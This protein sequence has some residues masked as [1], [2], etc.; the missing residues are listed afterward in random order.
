M[1]NQ[2]AVLKENIRD[3]ISKLA[4]DT[5][6]DRVCWT[7]FYPSQNT[8]YYVATTK[9]KKK[10]KREI[11]LEIKKKRTEKGTYAI[12]YTEKYGLFMSYSEIKYLEKLIGERYEQILKK[13]YA[14]EKPILNTLQDTAKKN[15]VNESQ[16]VAYAAA[17]LEMQVRNDGLVHFLSNEC[18]GAAP[19]ICVALETL[20]AA[21]HLALLQ[22][23]LTKNKVDLTD[24]SV[25][26][27]SELDAFSKLNEFYD[28]SD[29]K[30]SYKSLPSLP[31]YIRAYMQ[32]HLE[33]F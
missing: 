3:L 11:L 18:K 7:I 5:I 30:G 8:I 15:W 28:F 27:T 4:N 24:L 33:D 12:V 2:M 31:Q 9:H 17:S 22:A 32:A 1:D 26:D 19:Y 25:F 23:D 29:L 13:P 16:K 20:G 21:E 14:I 10:K 6:V